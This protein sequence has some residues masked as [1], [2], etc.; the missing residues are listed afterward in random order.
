MDLIAPA[1]PTLLSVYHEQQIKR[2]KEVKQQHLADLAEKDPDAV[3][4]G[5]KN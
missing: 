3:S 5:Q 1:S 4:A 2:A